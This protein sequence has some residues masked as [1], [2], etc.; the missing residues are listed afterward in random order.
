[1]SEAIPKATELKFKDIT[2]VMQTL[3]VPI[4]TQAKVTP[5]HTLGNGAHNEMKIATLLNTIIVITTGKA[6]S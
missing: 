3:N 2:V 4:T 1:M 6:D 5:T